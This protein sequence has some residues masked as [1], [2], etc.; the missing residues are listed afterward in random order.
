[1][2]TPV[3]FNGVSYTIPALAD[4]SW[5]AN[6]SNYLIAIASGCL[7]KT[8]GTFTLTAEVNFGATYGIKTA[9]LKSQTTN[10]AAAG[11]ARIAKTDTLVWRNNANDGDLPLGIDSSN[12]LTFN[13][14]IITAL[15]LGAANTVLR[16]NAGG[17]ATEYAKLTTSNLDAAAGI[18]DTQLATISTASKVSNSATTAASANTASAI[19]ARDGSGNFT[20]GTITAALVGN[21]STATTVTTNAN[22]TGPVTSV[23]NATAIADGALALA[24]LAV[25]TAGFIPVGA[26]ST[27]IPTYVAVSGDATLASTGALTLAVV[28]PAK[29]GTGV[30][31]NAAC[32]TTRSGNFA[33]TETL[34]NTTT[35]TYPTTGTLST[36]AGAEVI[37][38]KDH[39]GGTASNTSRLTVPK[40]TLANITALTRKQATILYD[41][42]S[43]KLMVDDGS[44]LNGVGSGAGELNCIANPSDAG[45]WTRTGT[46]GAAGNVPATTTTA[47]DLPL[48]TPIATAIKL[49]SATSTGA[50]DTAYVSY[51]FT[52][53]ASLGAKLK[54]EFY[55]RPGSNFIA[56]EW[57]VSIYQSTTRQALSTDSSAITYLPNAS[58][59]FTTTFDAVASTAYTLRFARTV[60]AGTNAAQLNLAN[61]I[62]GPGIQPQGAAVGPWIAFT[63]VFTASGG[64]T[65][66]I[67]TGGTPYSQ[68]YYRRNGTNMDMQVSWRFGTSSATFGTSGDYHITTPG[69]LTIDGSAIA[70]TGSGVAGA[71]GTGY[72]YDNSAADFFPLT[73]AYAASAGWIIF[74]VVNSLSGANLGTTTPVTLA[75]D[76]QF[77]FTASVPIS[78]WA[79]S[80]TVNLAQ[81]D[82][83]YASNS[84]TSTTTGDTTS[85]AYG[86]AGS[87]IQSITVALNRRVRFRSP[88]Q[89]T[90]A[91]EVE[92]SADGVRWVPVGGVIT[93]SANT[94]VASL[95]YDGTDETGIGLRSSTDVAAATDIDVRFG[96]KRLTG[97]TWA[98]VAALFWRVKKSSGGQAVG[99]GLVNPGVSAGL[100][101]A[102]G[103]A[104]KTNGVA[105][106]A[107][108]VGQ[109]RSQASGGAAAWTSTQYTDGGN[110]G[111]TLQAGVWMV[112]ADITHTVA[113]DSLITQYIYGVLATT[114]GNSGPTDAT[115]YIQ[116]QPA[117]HTPTGN[118][119]FVSPWMIVNISADTVYYPKMRITGTR[120]SG[121]V[122]SNISAVRIA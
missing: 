57:T 93:T 100:V 122:T 82:V 79:G 18:V 6:V 1:M 59:K 37:T 96:T 40:D 35:V 92:M 19:V 72:L 74:G 85:F 58:G 2:S 39:D 4:A 63:P 106:G 7:Q 115:G 24:K 12:R 70:S 14:A 51:A 81:N 65:V 97:T 87:A 120:S 68:G 46:T 71:V 90:D 108:Y 88:I 20:A 55:M 43:N 47:G 98:S 53:P 77:T 116:F 86:P 60:N 49:L 8:G 25:T 113:S 84:S 78:E 32:T 28:G 26:V 111:L 110:T 23:G 107:G 67:G 17:T 22:L 5:A 118:Q 117:S 21:A 30:A 48:S 121:T 103:L 50:E 42:T 104:G 80:G 13:S 38:L 3:T 64:G 76:D 9:Y 66:A 10:I 33:K 109:V 101:S 83:E 56:S 44:N 29:G 89:A 45:N 105:V 61:V 99:F 95:D 102:N 11:W 34:T 62:V 36:L 41:T 91:V 31:N 27:G 114:S 119:N 112:K 52:T 73:P 54:V 69:G 15:A 75:I 16:M 94:G